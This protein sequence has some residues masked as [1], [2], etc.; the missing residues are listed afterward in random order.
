MRRPHLVLRRPIAGRPVPSTQPR[1]PAALLGPNHPLV[2]GHELRGDLRR[3]S[4]LTAAAVVL[5]AI[6]TA[7]G[8]S[9]GLPLLVA[10][11]I[12][13]LGLV[14]A[15]ALL[16]AAQRERARE[17]IIARRGGLP[18]PALEREL[19]RLQRPRLRAGLADALEE[20]VRAA[21]RWPRLVPTSR[22][23]FDPRQVQAAA[24]ELRAIAAR[25]RASRD[26]VRAVARVQRLLTSGASPLYGREPE[27]LRDELMR[28]H[29]ELDRAGPERTAPRE[30]AHRS[31]PSR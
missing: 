8:R 15:L 31:E 18:L 10:A 6:G 14:I 26:A 3:Q 16:S 27:A 29:A 25:L 4:L 9:W 12:V 7:S 5:G 19:L 13:Q 24:A 17:L 21:E 30:P 11:A 23:V 28:I 2:R 1:S 22:P 20:L